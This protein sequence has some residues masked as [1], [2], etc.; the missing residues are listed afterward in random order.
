MTQTIFMIGARAAGKTTLGKALARA[1][2]YRF[3]D[4]DLYMQDTLG[5]TVAEIV[6]HEG[7]KGFRLRE[8]TA[9][10]MATAPS[11]VVATGGGMVLRE[12]NRRFMRESGVVLYL[13][14]PA[15]ILGAR[16]EAAPCADQRPT[17]TGLPIAEEMADV[18]AEREP[19]YRE[20]ATYVLD[21][22]AS[23]SVILAEARRLLQAG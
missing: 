3:V 8:G 20:T 13:H 4:T 18:L 17:L 7:W 6:A 5:V 9:L 23:P 12:E 19:L 2:G 14:A 10:R 15:E 21:A 22:T 1:L 11:T 16:L